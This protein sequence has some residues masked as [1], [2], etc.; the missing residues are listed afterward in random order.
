MVVSSHGGVPVSPLEEAQ[1]Q[2]ALETSQ[3]EL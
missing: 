1:R 2:E 3:A